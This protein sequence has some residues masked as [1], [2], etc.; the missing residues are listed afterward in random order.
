MRFVEKIIYT[1][2]EMPYYCKQIA[3]ILPEIYEQTQ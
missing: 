2:G 1:N 3:V